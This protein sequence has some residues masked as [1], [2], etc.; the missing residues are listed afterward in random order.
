MA[1]KTEIMIQK[2]ADSNYDATT[3]ENTEK[4]GLIVEKELSDTNWN[5]NYS[6][7]GVIHI[8][9]S[10]DAITK[11]VIES[12]KPNKSGKVKYDFILEPQLVRLATDITDIN[13]GGKKTTE[14]EQ[15]D[16]I[17]IEEEQFMVLSN[18]YGK[19]VAMPYYNIT[20][21]TTNPIQRAGGQTLKFS[22]S[23]FWTK[24]TK[25]I[26]PIENSNIYKYIYAYQGKL[27]AIVGGY[28]SAKMPRMYGEEKDNISNFK[29]IKNAEDKFLLNPG[30]DNV[31]YWIGS[32]QSPWYDGGV[33]ITWAGGTFNYRTFSNRDSGVRPV[34]IIDI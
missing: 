3:I 28:V 9:Y 4:L 18:D 24:G 16:T 33:I 15:G 26:E 5:I 1:V 8:L 17:K 6:K 27:Q 25:N 34:I 32:T 14:V 19:I 12:G 2:V 13:Y 31:N 7:K 20:L 30:N 23:Q 11:D 22:E 10:N 21:S 29:S